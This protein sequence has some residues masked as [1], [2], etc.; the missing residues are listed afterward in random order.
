MKKL[1]LFAVLPLLLLIAAFVVFLPGDDGPAY[2]SVAV[3]RGTLVREAVA[4]GRIEPRFEVPVTSRNGGVL[5]TKFVELGQR[6]AKDEPLV[7]VRPVLTDL[8]LL[9]AERALIAAREARE[10]ASELRAGESLMGRTMLFFQGQNNVERMERGVERSVSD[11]EERLELLVEGKAEIGGKV[12]DFVVR[13]P[14]EGHVIQ[15][16]AEL[17]EPVVPASSYGTGTELLILADMDQPVF[18][19]TV[20]EIDVGRLREG[21]RAELD[22]GALPGTIVEGE[23][24]EVSLRSRSLN[25]ATV[26]DVK[27]SVMP[28]EALVLRSGY[29][30]VARIEL[31]RVADVLV[32][33][34][35][36]VDYRD[37]K[38]VVLVRDG[39]EGM[40]EREIA[41]G[42]SDGLTVEIL[43]GLTEGDDVLEQIW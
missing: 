30:A 23:L 17:G 20:N 29:S 8:D 27:L 28:P 4:S 43:E 10:N 14:I 13:A 19:G 18:R 41:V 40:V 6:V 34:E 1:L 25:N 3:T 2:Q 35:R 16:D 22:I 36:V 39:S 37:G 9:Q 11:A 24:I 12:I 42:L 21:M 38:A 15:L 32:L 7:E 31:A 26:F 33:P 5:T